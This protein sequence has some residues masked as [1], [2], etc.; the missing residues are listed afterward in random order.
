[1]NTLAR[2]AV[3]VAVTFARRAGRLAV[4]TALFVAVV[5]LSTYFIGLAALSGSA[6]QSISESVP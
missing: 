2:R 3:D 4:G 1:M 5:A 6:H